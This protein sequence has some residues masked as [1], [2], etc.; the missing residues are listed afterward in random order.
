VRSANNTAVEP[1]SAHT[2]TVAAVVTCTQCNAVPEQVVDGK[3]TI[4]VVRHE[5]G[6]P[7]LMALSGLPPLRI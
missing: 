2:D 4:A 6:W 1:L 3:A 5:L 7:T